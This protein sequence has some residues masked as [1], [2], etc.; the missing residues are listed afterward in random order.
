MKP[1]TIERRRVLHAERQRERRADL[2]KRLEEKA[3]R[4]PGGDWLEVIKEIRAQAN[5][6]SA[7]MIWRKRRHGKRTT[8]F[9]GPD[10]KFKVYYVAQFRP[11][12]PRKGKLW[13]ASQV[14]DA[15]P[16][17]V[18]GKIFKIAARSAVAAIKE[19]RGL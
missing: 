1:E 4:D 2:I 14:I 18:V 7:P 10:P 17:S 13:A 12:Y 19:A 3:K 15:L 16:P 5:P 8:H 6:S 11:A 9:R